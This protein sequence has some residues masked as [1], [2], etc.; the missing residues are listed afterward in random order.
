MKKLLS[1]P[2]AILLFLLSFN[3]SNSQATV[4]SVSSFDASATLNIGSSIDIIVS[5]N[6]PV[7]VTGTPKLKLET[8]L[9]DTKIDYVSGSGTP[10]LTFTYVVIE[11]NTSSDLDY[12]NTS[13]L[14]LE[15][16]TIT[17]PGNIAANLTL[18]SPGGP[19]SLA[20]I[21][22]DEKNCFASF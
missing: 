20:G 2:L 19:G 22:D 15:G 14:T 10:F 12:V 18:P 21:G 6:A 5:F 1:H 17:G 4:S 3:F 7:T 16:G 13:A 9:T 8:G 11:G